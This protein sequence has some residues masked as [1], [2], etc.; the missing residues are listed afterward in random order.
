MKFS[1]FQVSSFRFQEKKIGALRGT[2]FTGLFHTI[3]I[4]EVTV[5]LKRKKQI[6][7][8]KE[9]GIHKHHQS[10]G[11]EVREQLMVFKNTHNLSFE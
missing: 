10:A 5:R 7:H 8:F 6:L 4:A 1:M 2:T 11:S 3:P 9:V